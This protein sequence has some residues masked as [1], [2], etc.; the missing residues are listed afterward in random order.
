M[1]QPN[2]SKP[3][4]VKRVTFRLELMG[5]DGVPGVFADHVHMSRTK[6]R[7]ILSF[8]QHV[9]PI[10]L[11]GEDVDGGEEAILKSSLVARVMLEDKTAAQLTTILSN[12]LTEDLPEGEGNEHL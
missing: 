8:F 12:A 6:G 9:F 10:G 11:P 4:K 7:V 1:D 3:N 5:H 2:D